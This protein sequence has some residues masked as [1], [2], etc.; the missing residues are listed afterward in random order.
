MRASEQGN[1][2]DPF[3]ALI[4]LA[5]LLGVLIQGCSTGGGPSYPLDEFR[6]PVSEEVFNVE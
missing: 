2:I 1:A 3:P 6:D 4:A 5:A